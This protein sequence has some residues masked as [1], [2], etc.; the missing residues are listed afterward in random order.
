MTT[1]KLR[2]VLGGKI[3]ASSLVV[4]ER[5]LHW[6]ERKTGSHPVGVRW[7]AAAKQSQGQVQQ[8]TKRPRMR[9]PLHWPRRQR[10]MTR[11]ERPWPLHGGRTVGAMR[12][13]SSCPATGCCCCVS[14]SRSSRTY[15]QFRSDKTDRGTR[16]KSEMSESRT[17]SVL[18]VRGTAALRVRCHLSRRRPSS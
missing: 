10:L 8:Q 6:T 15:W 17:A 2:K 7:W 18:D 13:R 1:T 12:F 14:Y 4:I 3:S 11:G 5:V 9:A 16:V